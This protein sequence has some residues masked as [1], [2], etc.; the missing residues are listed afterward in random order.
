[1]TKILYKINKQ[2]KFFFIK[3]FFVTSTQKKLSPYVELP[4]PV[5]LFRAYPFLQILS[6][7]T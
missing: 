6:E 3:I 4:T 2:T 7:T 1:M 5:G